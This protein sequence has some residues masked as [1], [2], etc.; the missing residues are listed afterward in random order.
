MVFTDGRQIGATL[1]RNGLRPARF[2]VTDDDVVVLAS[3]AGVLPIDGSCIVRKWR[4]QP[5][6]MFVIDLELGRIIE[7]EE[8]KLQFVVAK[9]YAQWI[10]NIRVGLVGVSEDGSSP[11]TNLPPPFNECVLNRQQAFGYSQDVSNFQLLPMVLLGQAP[12][13]S[14]GIDAS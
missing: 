6:K 2:V 5:G 7:D 9:F 13:S 4:V 8:F 14:M 11:S 3:E 10:D 1:D 12:I